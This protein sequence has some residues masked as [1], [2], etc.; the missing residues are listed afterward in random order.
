MGDGF[1]L[2]VVVVVVN[3][4]VAVAAFAVVTLAVISSEFREVATHK[5]TTNTY[6]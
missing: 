4:A 6:F 2:V 3:V 5:M 1:L